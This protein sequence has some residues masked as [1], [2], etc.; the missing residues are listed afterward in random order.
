[1][2]LVI[3]SDYF[4]SQYPNCPELLTKRSRPYAYLEITIDGLRFAIP[5]R[6]HISHKWAYITYGEC[7]LDYTKAV[8]ISDPRFISAERAVIEQREFNALKGKEMRIASGMSRYLDAYRSACSHP[9]NHHY[10][11][12]RRCSALQY[13]HAQL[14]IE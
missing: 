10:D 6:H 2:R 12:I 11:M 13:F 4:F 1:M 8:I 7:G 5:F 3:L 14:S 9:G